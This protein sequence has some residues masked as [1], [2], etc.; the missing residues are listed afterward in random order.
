[1]ADPT[2]LRVFVAGATGAVGSLFVPRA[3]AAGLTVLPHVRP[4][5]AERHPLG[6]D[7]QAQVFDLGDAA[8]LEQA[9]AGVDSV[10]CLVGTMRRRFDAGDTYESSDY[11]PVVELVQAAQRAAGAPRHVVLL[12]SFGARESA[13][14]LGW[15]WKAEQALRQGGLPWTILR[16]SAF[17][18]RDTES[19]PSD[20][21]AR[22]PPPLMGSSLRA[23]GRLPGL[24]G[25]ADDLRPI[26]L[27][28]LVAA[29][30]RVV[31]ERGPQGAVLTGR[32]LWTLAGAGIDPSARR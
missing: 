6:Q 20:G 19:H 24:R 15:K 17:D 13:G 30:V 25:L 11:R 18:S 23:L 14:Y 27:D 12:S 8:R 26:S 29:L 28:V 1:M 22:R 7:P 5:T 21:R 31:V 32:N 9:L 2:P 3:R 4:Q 16:P 10:V